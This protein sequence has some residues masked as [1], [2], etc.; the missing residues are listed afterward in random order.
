MIGYPDFS[1]DEMFVLAGS[2]GIGRTALLQFLPWAGV[3]GGYRL[4]AFDG[5]H[6]VY[7]A[8]HWEMTEPVHWWRRLRLKKVA[9]EH[10]RQNVRCVFLVEAILGFF[11]LMS[12]IRILFDTHQTQPKG[13]EAPSDNL[14]GD[15]FARGL[16]I[17][18]R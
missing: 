10:Y 4:R 7:L 3:L 17:R 16:F 2:N 14:A 18:E 15:L 11:W 12:G 9:F 5:G 6:L 8:T 1:L 13:D